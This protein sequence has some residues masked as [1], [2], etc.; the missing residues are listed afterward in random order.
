L[1]RSP[2]GVRRHLLAASI[3]IITLAVPAPALAARL[4]LASGHDRGDPDQPALRYAEAEAQEFAALMQDLGGVRPG[5]S[6][7]LLGPDREQLVWALDRLHHRAGELVGQ[8]ERVEVFVYFSGHARGGAL[9]LAGEA[10]ELDE[11]RRRLELLPADVLVAVT[12]ACTAGRL[13]RSKG[14]RQAGGDYAMQW[15]PVGAPTGRVLITSS[16][17]AEAAFE[18]DRAG[19]SLF[20]RSLVAALRGAA[21]D[22]GDGAVTLA[23]GYGYLYAHTLA[24]S[25]EEAGTAQHPHAEVSI[26]GAGP[27][28]LTRPGVDGARLTLPIELAGSEVWVV[29]QSAG[30]AVVELTVPAGRPTTLALYPGRFV[31]YVRDGLRARTTTVVL[32]ADEERELDASRGQLAALEPLRTRGGGLIARRWELS[33]GYRLLGPLTDQ[34]ATVS[35][36]WGA[37]EVQPLPLLRLGITAFAGGGRFVSPGAR[38]D[39]AEV[40]L[41][42]SV[43]ISPVSRLQPLGGVRVGVEGIFQS[44]S[45]RDDRGWYSVEPP[46]PHAARAAALRLVGEGGVLIRIG[47]RATFRIIVGGGATWIPGADG[48]VAR[49]RLEATIGLGVSP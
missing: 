20:A 33:G 40:G 17:V 2:R 31:V 35:A 12:D 37:L 6:T 28:V 44:A 30:R 36:G 14:L 3:L 29:D 32:A 1:T 26:Q 13:L 10:F 7:V 4:L 16:G 34:G 5:D 11:L 25:L 49:P 21:D 42:G 24:S 47:S 23:E 8:G 39:Q 18:S 22:D 9:S 43:H 38:F 19:G 27:L 15:Q 48:L 41:D 45:A 46:D